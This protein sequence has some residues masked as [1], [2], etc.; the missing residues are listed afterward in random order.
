MMQKGML[1]LTP[2]KEMKKGKWSSEITKKPDTLPAIKSLMLKFQ[3]CSWSHLIFPLS[4]LASRKIIHSAK[5]HCKCVFS[6]GS[7]AAWWCC[8]CISILVFAFLPLLIFPQGKTRGQNRFQLDTISLQ[9]NS[10][11]CP[12]GP[13]KT[14]FEALVLQIIIPIHSYSVPCVK[15]LSLSQSLASLQS[16]TAWKVTFSKAPGGKKGKSINTRELNKLK[17]WPGVFSFLQNT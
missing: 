4:Q 6:A 9:I 14:D 3:F 16:L 7:G 5:Q 8:E 12:N 13:W 10:W 1:A 15:A 11:A 17:S 2:N